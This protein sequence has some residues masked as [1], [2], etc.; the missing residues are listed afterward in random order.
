MVVVAQFSAILKFSGKA[1]FAC[2]KLRA[3]IDL[4]LLGVKRTLDGSIKPTSEVSKMHLYNEQIFF[5]QFLPNI[6]N[7]DK[8]SGF[9]SVETISWASVEKMLF[10]GGKRV[11]SKNPP[12]SVRNIEVYAITK[13]RS[14]VVAVLSAKS[15]TT[16]FTIFCLRI[17]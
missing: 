17:L 6:I 1:R 7:A 12:K 8:L 13:H 2:Q 16:K 9:L 4:F 15:S 3:M 11:W 14:A 5:H 10:Y